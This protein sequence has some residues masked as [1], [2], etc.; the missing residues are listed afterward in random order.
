[1]EQGAKEGGRDAYDEANEAIARARRVQTM[2]DDTPRAR[3]RSGTSNGWTGA[4]GVPLPVS[5]AS[6]VMSFRPASAASGDLLRKGSRDYLGEQGA[7]RPGTST[8]RSS[9]DMLYGGVGE[10]P[11][12]PGTSMSRNSVDGYRPTSM[13]DRRHSTSMS[14]LNG[15]RMYDEPN[16]NY[17]QEE[18]E[19]EEEV[20]SPNPF[21]LPPPPM[22]AGSRFDPKVLEAQRK[23]IDLTRPLSRLSISSQDR[24]SRF[25]PNPIDQAHAPA[26]SALTE[27]HLQQYL[28]G[29][30]RPSHPLEQL[31][32]MAGRDIQHFD[33]IPSAAEYGKPLRAPKYGPPKFVDRRSLL[34]PKTLIMPSLLTDAP[35]PKS[36]PRHVPDGYTLGAKPLPAG[37]RSSILSTTDLRAQSGGRGGIPL[38][39]SQK[40]FRSSLM[41]G[42]KREEE[43]YWVGGATEEGDVGV[44]YVGDVEY[45][46]PVDRRP[47]KL[48]VSLGD[49]MVAKEWGADVKGKSLM[50]QLEAR[51]AAMKGKQR[52]CRKLYHV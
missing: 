19:E 44:E 4:E 36:P 34:R 5:P 50:D 11:V 46:G 35:P 1:M 48:Y 31:D 37:A 39:L 40:T 7:G 10:G 27:E 13:M 15:G 42:G 28:T 6:T 17:R 32:P 52:Y 41:V 20:L 45:E 21:A 14:L 8:S 43:E 26:G 25:H 16:G 51:K 23:S 30:R 49:I 9:Y 3:T 2:Y 22:E 33:E 24:L 47:G 29:G 18:E 12:R 38:S